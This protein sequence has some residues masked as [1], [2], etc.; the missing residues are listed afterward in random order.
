[1]GKIMSASKQTVVADLILDSEH[2]NRGKIVVRLNCINSNNDDII[3]KFQANLVPKTVL[4]C[5]NGTNNPYFV[6][7]RARDSTG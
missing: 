5:C 3:F 7:S 4:S 6:F 2:T 1:M